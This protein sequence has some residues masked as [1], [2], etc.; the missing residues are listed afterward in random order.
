M[1]TMTSWRFGSTTEGNILF[2]LSGKAALNIK[3]VTE[4]VP[5][6]LIR[7]IWTSR[8]HLD[9]VYF[10]FITPNKSSCVSLQLI[11]FGVMKEKLAPPCLSDQNEGFHTLVAN[12]VFAPQVQKNI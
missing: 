12:T 5:T 1:L 3:I 4:G 8:P 6:L 11:L 9:R 7:E 10:S 2:V